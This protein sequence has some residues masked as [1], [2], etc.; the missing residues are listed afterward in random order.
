MKSIS[1]RINNGDV[2]NLSDVDWE[3]ETNFNWATI[4]KEIKAIK[5]REVQILAIECIAAQYKMR[6]GKIPMFDWWNMDIVKSLSILKEQIENRDKYD[7][8]KNE[9]SQPKKR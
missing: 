8:S 9:C 5:G 3:V 1:E 7:V 4:E 2:A 6:A